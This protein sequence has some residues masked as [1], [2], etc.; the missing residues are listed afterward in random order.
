MA[1]RLEDKKA[2]VAEVSTV[3]KS[4]ISAVAADYRGLDVASMTQLR[5]HARQAGLYLRV[6]RNTLARRAVAGTEFECLQDAL[7]GPM[8]LAFSE[9]S[10]SAPA[11]LFRDFIKENETLEVKAIALSGNLLEASQLENIAK[12]PTKDE[13]IATLMMVM[14][15][16]VTQLVRTMAEPHGKLVRTVA[17]VKDQ[18]QAA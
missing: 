4:A 9:D 14:K 2:I 8:I 3:A 10:P 17:A 13:A 15:A 5:N 6:V 11:R 12:L 1:L 18:K 16:P 7:V